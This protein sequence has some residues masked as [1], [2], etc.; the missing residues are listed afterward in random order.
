MNPTTVSVP[1][2]IAHCIAPV[3]AASRISSAVA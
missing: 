2:V 1:M 3:A